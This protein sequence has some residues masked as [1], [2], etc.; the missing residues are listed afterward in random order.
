MESKKKND[1]EAFE[2]IETNI[3]GLI[4]YVECWL[5]IFGEFKKRKVIIIIE[6]RFIQ[7][8]DLIKP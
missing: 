4:V 8:K 5:R 3:E 1:I 7:S 6:E 2:Q